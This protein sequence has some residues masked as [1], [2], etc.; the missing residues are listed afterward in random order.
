MGIVPPDTVLTP[1][2]KGL[3]TWN[4]LSPD[5]KIVAELQ[6]ENLAGFM[7]QTDYEI[8][9][10]IHAMRQGPNGQ[11]TLI[12]F[13]AGDNGAS[14]DN[15]VRG[16][17]DCLY[18]PPPLS[19][20]RITYL[21][22]LVG[23]MYLSESDAGWAFMND[24]PFPGM[25]R[26][27]STLGGTTGPLIVSWAGHTT[28]NDVFAVSI[29]MSPTSL[30]RFTTCSSIRPQRCS[31]GSSRFRW[32]AHRLRARLNHPGRYPRITFSILTASE[33]EPFTRMAG[34]PRIAI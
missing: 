29:W 8:G 18:C 31:T 13:I 32:R 11:N 7:S 23:P 4:S 25:K 2:D 26:D 33:K 30:R 22:K 3:R 6:M 9:R 20:A 21:N 24:T 12:F 14:G 28:R 1:R 5:E 10:L 34:W 27:A 19:K 17:D 15:G 16:C